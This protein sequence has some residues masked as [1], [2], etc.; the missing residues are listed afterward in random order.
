MHI[1]NLLTVAL[2]SAAMATTAM[3]ALSPEKAE[4]GKGPAQFLMTKEEQDRWKTLKTDAEADEFIALFWARRDPTP[5]TPANEFLDEYE[6]RVKYA[7]ANFAAGKKKGSLTDRG[8]ILVLFGAPTKRQ[9]SGEGPRSTIDTRGFESRETAV[10]TNASRK[11]IWTYEGPV[12]QPF[13]APQAKINFVDQF[14]N[15]EFRVEQSG[16]DLKAAS[17]RVIQATMTQPNLTVE[18]LRKPAPAA[19]A[20]PAAPAAPVAATPATTFKTAEF[21]TAVDA[22]Q[23]AKTNPYKAKE[24]FVSWGEFVTPAGEYFVPVSLYVPNTTGLTATQD[25]TFFGVIEDTTGKPVAVFEEPV[26]LAA[27][28]SDLFFDKTLTLPAGEFTGTFGLAEGGKPLTMA[29]TSMK[30]AGT[31]DKDAAGASGLILSNN[32]Y[33][34][35][36]PQRPTDPFAFG[37]IKVVPKADRLFTTSDDLWYFFELRNP[38]VNETG[39]PQIQVKLDME[40]VLADG[41]KA[42]YS[43]P[44][45]VVETIE[46]KGVPG[47]YGLGSS[48]PLSSFKP[49]T[50]TLK[51]KA[52]DTVKKMTYTM[53]DTFKIVAAGGK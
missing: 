32:I 12:A 16:F 42:V 7:D 37:G 23:A 21:Q 25:L 50:Y 22:F 27:T 53:Q 48:M 13:N 51:I 29:T 4:W 31:L 52:I 44:P 46:L 43:N 45:S 36:E 2:L 14:N 10:A 15:N 5:G 26:K 6:S 41:K 1:R 30:L 24:I 40:G 47:H 35:T 8:R 49:G 9:V 11:E 20:A 3:A 33:P 34:L 28:K 17:A 18:D 39:K 38:G 19:V